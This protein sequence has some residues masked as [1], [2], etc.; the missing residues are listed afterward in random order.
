MA[1][2]LKRSSVKEQ[3]NNH[4]RLSAPRGRASTAQRVAVFRPLPPGPVWDLPAD[5]SFWERRHPLQRARAA[6]PCL[7][8]CRLFLPRFALSSDRVYTA[9][10]GADRPIL[11]GLVVAAKA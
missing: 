4:A 5:W 9:A 7:M 2:K 8:R 3:C 6:R 11:F 1:R 10:Y